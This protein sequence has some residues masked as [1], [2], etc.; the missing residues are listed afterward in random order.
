M[1]KM[2]Q[3]IA[4]IITVI[5]TG[6]TLVVYLLSER[7]LYSDFGCG[8]SSGCVGYYP[9]TGS[10]IIGYVLLIAAALIFITSILRIRKFSKWWII[11]ALIVSGIALYG[12]GYMIF[13]KGMCGLSINK[14]TFFIHQT[15]LGDFAAEDGETI[16]MD[17]LKTGKYKGKLLGYSVSG[18]E[19][20]LYRIGASPLKIKTGFLFW[21]TSNDLI[22]LDLSPSLNSFRNMDFEKKGNGYEF[23]GGQDMPVEVFMAEFKVAHKEFQGGKIKNQRVVNEPDGTTRFRFET[24]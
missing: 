6:L 22:I 13:N 24:E 18:K 9:T 19:L 16:Y 15:K 20:T 23:I 4:I 14:A 2:K 7:F 8:C 21:K 3:G 12:N 10:R 11:P 5:L 17:S 1:G